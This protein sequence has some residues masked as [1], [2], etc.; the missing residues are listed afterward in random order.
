MIEIKRK[1]GSVIMMIDAESL[2]RVNLSGRDFRN[3]DL[4]GRNLE[5][6]FFL[7]AIATGSY[8]R[9]ADLSWAILKNAD[10]RECD[11]RGAHLHGVDF[12]GAKLQGADFRDA[13]M[14]GVNLLGADLTGANLEGANVLKC[15]QYVAIIRASRGSI[16]AID[17][18]IRI[19]CQR[20]TLAEWLEQFETVG[21]AAGY[22]EQQIVEYGIY[23]RA[24]R[25][26][27]EVRK[28]GTTER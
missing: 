5:F 9:G 8:L 15:K 16:V 2:R 28:H 24:I 4:R 23:L 13:Y 14:H 22:T 18:D 27:L 12:S 6:G 3:A 19:G 20:M 7:G 10:F 26:V 1:D 21:R 25:D 17:D 11:F